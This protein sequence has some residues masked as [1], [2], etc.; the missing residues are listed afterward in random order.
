MS[1]KS[2]GKMMDNLKVVESIRN[3][4]TK[5]NILVSSLERELG[6]GAGLISRWE[7]RD[8]SLSKII[9]IA[10]YFHVSIDEVVGYEPPSTNTLIKMLVDATQA[11]KLKWVILNKSDNTPNDFKEQYNKWLSNLSSKYSNTSF[12][13]KHNDIILFVYASHNAKD[14]HEPQEIN[15]CMVSEGKKISTYKFLLSEIKPLWNAILDNREEKVVKDKKPEIFLSFS[16]KKQE[17]TQKEL[18]EQL[19]SIK[20]Y[21][22]IIDVLGHPNTGKSLFLINS[23]NKILEEYEK[24]NSNK[25]EQDE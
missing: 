13:S 18:M 5:N 15:L 1:R 10:D 11:S 7:T 17:D 3:L 2:I 23:F 22:N 4:C 14:L 25:E 12:C 21:D 16:H 6:F 9:A 20:N 24:N 8:P 19:L